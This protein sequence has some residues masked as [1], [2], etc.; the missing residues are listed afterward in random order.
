MTV[1][2]MIAK[3]AATVAITL[4]SMTGIMVGLVMLLYG[5]TALSGDKYYAQEVTMSIAAGG[6]LVVTLCFIVAFV[7]FPPFAR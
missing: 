4:V 1:L 2:L 7:L 3:G 5:R 6:L